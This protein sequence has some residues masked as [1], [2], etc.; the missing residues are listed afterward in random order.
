MLRRTGEQRV[1]PR[2]CRRSVRAHSTVPS[3]LR[4][5]STQSSARCDGRPQVI[6]E[7]AVPGAQPVVPHAGGDVR[8]H[9]GVE[10]G[11]LDRAVGQV[12]VPPAAVGTLDV[13]EPLVGA[14]GLG[15]AGRRR[16]APS[17]SRRG[18]TGRS[19]RRGT[20][21]SCRCRSCSAAIDSA[22]LHDLVGAEHAVDVRACVLIG[23][24]PVDDEA[25]AQHGRQA[26]ARAP[27]SRAGCS[28]ISHSSS[29]R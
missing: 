7:A 1:V 12:V 10:L 29:S 16:R 17:R 21:G 13:D 19:A 20:T 4:M 24:L 27:S 3:G 26:H 9:V 8:A 22:R 15:C 14:L 5:P 23:L 6:D 11:L 28:V 25:L 2:T 18:S